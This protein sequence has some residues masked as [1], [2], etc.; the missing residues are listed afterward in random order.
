[1]QKHKLNIDCSQYLKARKLTR[2]V[3]SDQL[4]QSLKVEQ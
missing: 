1:M 3:Q 2:N 4:E